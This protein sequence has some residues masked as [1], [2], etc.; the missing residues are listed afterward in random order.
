MIVEMVVSG[1]WFA[2]RL[3]LSKKAVYCAPRQSFEF[4]NSVAGR[5]CFEFSTIYSTG[6]LL[7]KR[8]H[9]SFY[10]SKKAF[11]EPFLKF[12]ATPVSPQTGPTRARFLRG[13]PNPAR[14]RIAYK[15]SHNEG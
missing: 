7:A 3:D 1:W 10:L 8:V 12:H 14:F 9:E 2:L 4:S 13:K 6:L 11:S 5:Q 15:G